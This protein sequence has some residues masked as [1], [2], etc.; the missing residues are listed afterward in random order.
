M[1]RTMTLLNQR[2]LFNF[3]Q[4]F[5]QIH[6]DFGSVHTWAIA[7]K[8]KGLFISHSMMHK[9][10]EMLHFKIIGDEDPYAQW[11]EMALNTSDLYP[12]TRLLTFAGGHKVPGL[13]SLSKDNIQTF[14]YMVREAL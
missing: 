9:F 11:F 6:F 3:R 4:K 13:D 1:V 7:Y 2:K 12:N 10:E 5:P 14:D 8:Y